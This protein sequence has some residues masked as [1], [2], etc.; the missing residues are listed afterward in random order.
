MA[1]IGTNLFAAAALCLFLSSF[2]FFPVLSFNQPGTGRGEP[3][4]ML[5]VKNTA[6]TLKGQTKHG[7]S[8]CNQC[9]SEHSLPGARKEVT[10]LPCTLGSSQHREIGC[11]VGSQRRHHHAHYKRGDVAQKQNSGQPRFDKLRPLLQTLLS[12]LV[13]SSVCR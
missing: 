13:C 11:W 7:Y 4:L 8:T 9:R 10:A 5:K 1:R 6:G 12:L 2:R 3:C